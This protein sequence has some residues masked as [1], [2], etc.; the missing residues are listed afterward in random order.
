L[1]AKALIARRFW[2]SEYMDG[3][4]LSSYW[5]DAPLPA[6][7]QIA[8]EGARSRLDLSSGPLLAAWAPG[9]V[10]L[11]GEHTDYNGGY[12]LPIAIENVVAVAG[13]LRQ[14][15]DPPEMTSTVHLYSHHHD[16]MATLR[17][18]QLPSAA[19]PAD[20]PLWALYIAGVLG[21][22]IRAGIR[23]Q[24]F[25]ASI[26]GD[27]PTGQGLSSSAA[28]VMASLLWLNAALELRIPPLEMAQLG[29]RSEERGTGVRV[30]I[31]DHAA[32]VL[33]RPGLA[34]LI[35]CRS[36]AY[37]SIP[38]D[39]PEVSLLICDSGVERSLAASAYNERRHECE[40]ALQA[41]A[42]ALIA[43]AREAYGRSDRS[44]PY[45]PPTSLRDI[46]IHDL[47]RLGGRIPAPARQRAWHVVTENVRTL[48]A[49]EALESQDVRRL[50]ELMLASHASLR[51]QY[52]VS[53]SELDALVEISTQ[54]PPAY[55]ARLV[56]AGF[57]GG[58]LILAP[59]SVEA[60]IRQRLAVQ[61]PE[62]S[63]RPAKIMRIRPAGGPGLAT[64]GER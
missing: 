54:P 50:G 33:G 60:Q 14:P 3:A 9:R 49:V 20:Q 61:Y 43:E 48:G 42:S 4:S 31:L 52:A 39:L 63:G 25:A 32:S 18:D 6:P 24:G 8:V 21:E 51:D 16:Q 23:L 1:R 17:L 64:L 37:R 26:A 38:C 19:R 28:L 2:Y 56:G 30:G 40:I 27:V 57:G 58:V 11:I 59:E 15:T 5:S 45:Q 41:L 53:S 12:V 44:N 13:Q 34:V 35:D 22:L 47:R 7:A 29:Q 55:G 36:L 10:N 62:R 46:T